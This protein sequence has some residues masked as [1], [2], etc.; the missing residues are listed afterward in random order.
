LAAA[1]QIAERRRDNLVVA[2]RLKQ[3]PH[4]RGREIS[5]SWPSP[6]QLDANEI[7]RRERCFAVVKAAEDLDRPTQLTLCFFELPQSPSR[8]RR[9]SSRSSSASWFRPFGGH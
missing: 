8:R 9:S 4:G 1:E 5:V 7:A 2:Q 3:R 6:E